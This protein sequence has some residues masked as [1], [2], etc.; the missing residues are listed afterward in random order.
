MHIHGG[1]HAELRAA[2]GFHILRMPE[3]GRGVPAQG[4]LGS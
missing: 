2:A 1:A 4:I 3:P